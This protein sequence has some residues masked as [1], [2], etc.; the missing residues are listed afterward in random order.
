VE[1]NLVRCAC[2]LLEIF[3]LLG[4]GASKW[5]ACR[6]SSSP[7]DLIFLLSCRIKVFLSPFDPLRR[8][9]VFLSPFDPIQK[10]SELLCR[11]HTCNNNKVLS[12][13]PN[14]LHYLL[15]TCNWRESNRA[16][17]CA[18][19]PQVQGSFDASEARAKQMS[20]AQEPR[21]RASLF[22]EIS[23][24]LNSVGL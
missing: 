24:H 22:A 6:M 8:I 10:G 21:S 7:R 15:D 11:E 18:L 13:G 5:W 20:T 2:T 12:E 1:E 23:A 3:P 16:L 19:H 4:L 14:N 9:K 17:P